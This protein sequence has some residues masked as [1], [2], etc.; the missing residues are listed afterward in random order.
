MELHTRPLAETV[1]SIA[2]VRTLMN[3]Q[4]DTREYTDAEKRNEFNN[5]RKRNLATAWE[6]QPTER[7]LGQVNE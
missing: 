5:G 3:G 2:G 6:S 7:L 4:A 1:G